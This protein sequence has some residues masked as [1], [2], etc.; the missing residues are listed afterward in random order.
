MNKDNVNQ[1]IKTVKP[2]GLDFCS[3]VRTDRK[4]DAQKLKDLFKAIE[5]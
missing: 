3:G 1:A 5:S 4:L 2:F